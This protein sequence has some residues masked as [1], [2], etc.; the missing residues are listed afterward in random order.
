MPILI[1]DNA[2]SEI[3]T[4]REL[5]SFVLSVRRDVLVAEAAGTEAAAV[6]RQLLGGSVATADDVPEI[7]P[8]DDDNCLLEYRRCAE[9]G[10]N[11]GLLEAAIRCNEYSLG[12]YVPVL[13]GRH[14]VGWASHETLERLRPFHGRACRLT[15]LYPPV[16]SAK[17]GPGSGPG[18]LSG[19]GPGS[20]SGPW[21]GYGPGSEGCQPIDQPLSWHGEETLA[22]ELAPFEMT[23]GRRTQVVA[24]LVRSLVADGLIPAKKLRN[25]LQDVRPMREG[26][27][28][29]RGN[30]PILRME[31][32]AMIH[33]G[34]PSHGVHVNGYVR[35]PT[36][37]SDPRPHAVWIATR[38]MSK[39]TYPGLYDQVVAGGQPTS[40][41]VLDNV[42][43]EC[44]EEASLPPEVVAAVCPVGL[45]SYVYA[46]RKGLSSKRL[47]AFDVEMPDGLTPLCADGEV[48]EFRLMPVGEMLDSIRYQLPRWKP[49]SALVAIDFAMRHGLVSPDEPGFVQLAQMLRAAP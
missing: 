30:P 2:R 6:G 9:A 20:G 13:A 21:P 16:A 26:F 43:K 14:H 11:A 35:D 37:P 10:A 25:E 33:F 23:E 42:R 7:C 24:E 12:D 39:A 32:A 49:N 3:E 31:R 19:P 22:V 1:A 15:T 5:A 8:V 40:M 18:S 28:G 44:E 29:P 38:S 34:I 47:F 48:E 41:S 27:V 4:F 46:A 36:R 17:L 45:V